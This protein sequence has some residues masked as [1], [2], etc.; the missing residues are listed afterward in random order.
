MGNKCCVHCGCPQDYYVN[1][2]HASR[3]SCRLSHD[4]F[5]TFEL[6]GVTIA[7]YGLKK[8]EE[9]LTS[10]LKK[11]FKKNKRGRSDSHYEMSEI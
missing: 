4:K 8:T 10:C 5:H 7:K 6:E 9:S 11:I 2:H 3:S 1:A